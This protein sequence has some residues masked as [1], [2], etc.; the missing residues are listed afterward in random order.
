LSYFLKSVSVDTYES[1]FVVPPYTDMTL[2]VVLH[3][4]ILRFIATEWQKFKM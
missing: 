3:Y 1:R 2:R 4:T